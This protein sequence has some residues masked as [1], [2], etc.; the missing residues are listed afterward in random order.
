MAIRAAGAVLNILFSATLVFGFDLGVAGAAIGTTASTALVALIFTWGMTGR[1]YAGVG[2]S[3]IPIGR[4]WPDRTLL[5][6]LARV[7]IPLVARRVAQGIAVFPLLTIAATFGSVVLAAV[8]V[9]RQVRQ[10]LGSFTWGFSI[11]SSTLVG[12]A[13]GA[14]DEPLAV[15]YGREI[16]K[17][18]LVV[19]A[20]AAGI[21]M[22]FADPIAAIFVDAE[23]VAVTATFVAVTALSSVPLGVDGS[24]TG[25]LRGAGD[26][27]IPF[28]ATLAGLYL[29]TLPVAYLGTVTTL[30]STALLLALLAETGVPVL[31]NIARFRTGAWLGVSRAYR[32]DAKAGD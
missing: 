25:A 1:S 32:P 9:A 28:F 23:A 15:A 7:S 30:G 29:V 12:Q 13:L 6:Q 3:P 11:A 19:Y 16:T 2:A 20:L 18:S 5:S 26:T 21:V 17:L 8:G 31:V 10:L 24:V 14:A 4:V 22:V 27:R